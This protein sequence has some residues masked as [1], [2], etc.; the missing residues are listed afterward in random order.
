MKTLTTLAVLGASLFLLSGCGNNTNPPNPVGGNGF[1]QCTA[2]QLSTQYGCLSQGVCQFGM[3]QYGNTCIPGQQFNQN[4]P[5]QQNTQCMN[6]QVY[7]QYGCLNQG[8]CQIGMA[9]F[10]NTCVPAIN[11]NGLNNN[12]L[13]NGFNNGGYNGG[14]N[15]NYNYGYNYGY[16]TGVNTGSNCQPGFLS[17]NYGCLPQ[18]NCGTGR[19]L[20]QNTC[21]Q[22]YQ[23]GYGLSFQFMLSI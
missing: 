23:A 5:Y 4:N 11:N 17:T 14:F 18:A 19:V 9:Q 22:V 16:N 10:N 20:Y 3:A 2:G 15:Y 8:N 21:R 6:G 13:N 12:G 1:N 7:T